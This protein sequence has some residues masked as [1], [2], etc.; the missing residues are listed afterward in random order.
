MPVPSGPE[1]GRNAGHGPVEYCASGYFH[2]MKLTRAVIAV[3]PPL[4]A[5][6][7]GSV[8][9]RSAPTVYGRLRK[10]RWAPPS[11]VFAPVWTALYAL[12]G[13]AGWRMADGRVP[14]RT[15]LLHGAQLTLNALWPFM[16]FRI[17]DK[18]ASLAVIGVLDVLVALEL[19]DL[20]KQDKA[21]AAALTPY[22][23]WSL[24]ATALNAVVSDPGRQD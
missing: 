8:G 23:G 3:G 17:G 21:A 4:A 15:Q 11:G 14:V 1:R 12:I 7:I 5:A 13:F 24:F 9:S 6:V 10:P 20:V 16:F 2:E 19:A 22:L 18:R